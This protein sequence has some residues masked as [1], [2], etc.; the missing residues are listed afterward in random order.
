MGYDREHRLDTELTRLLD[1]LARTEPDN[2]V[3]VPGKRTRVEQLVDELSSQRRAQHV[4]AGPGRRTLVER[5]LSEANRLSF[6]DFR[7]LGLRD[8]LRALGRK[9]KLQS[10]TL[11]AADRDVARRAAA[12]GPGMATGSAPAIPVAL[13]LDASAHAD[14][15]RTVEGGGHTQPGRRQTDDVAG[16]SA[17]D[18][19]LRASDVEPSAAKIAPAADA[20]GQAMW[21]AAERRAVTL[22]RR[23]F[24]AGE[25]S[26]DDPA[27]AEA[28]ARAGGGAALP[29]AVRRKMEDELG[30]ALD[31]V[32]IHTDAVAA[33]ATRAVRAEAFTV[34]ED[35]FFADGAFA[36]E[37]R[38]GQKLLAHEL[39][40]VIQNWQGRGDSGGG[41][42]RVSRPGDSLEQE[43]DA[44]AERVADSAGR[45]D[46]T[47][48]A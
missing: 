34:G 25:V 21:R 29:A 31:R 20:A 38:A 27:V 9:R 2:A 35:I 12:S 4:A 17:N 44:V 40:H 19:R 48:R 41:A 13:P 16:G 26:P 39:T 7:V 14:H 18:G 45:T 36:P 24:D 46:G 5:L 33:Q 15:S 43:A 10:A 22:Y 32:R 1:D 30:V 28:L 6:D 3:D 47:D 42:V 37:S 11:D 23:A 8:V